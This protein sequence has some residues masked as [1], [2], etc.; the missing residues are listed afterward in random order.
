MINKSKNL[1]IN[2]GFTPTPERV[3]GKEKH[4]A[5]NA[6]L[7]RGFTM[8][9]LLIAIA[10]FSIIIGVVSGIFISSLRTSRTTLALISA[11]TDGELALDK[12]S[13]LI[14]KGWGDSFFIPT[15]NSSNNCL[16]F[17]YGDNNNSG[18]VTYRWNSAKKTLEANHNLNGYFPSCDS[19]ESSDFSEMVSANLRVDFAVFEKNT[20]VSQEFPKITIVLR[21]G[22]KNTQLSDTRVPFT[23]LQ[24]TISPRYDRRYS[25]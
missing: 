3:L 17:R 11:N 14:R 12:M 13:R 23:N 9:E 19:P 7:V 15:S 24:T 8:I 1:I 16:S 21:I 18:Y 4:K 2:T 25:N 22:T 20:T 5:F 10:V 6:R